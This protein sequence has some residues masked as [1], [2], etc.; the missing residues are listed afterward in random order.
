MERTLCTSP[1]EEES[2]NP[3]F[4]FHL[5]SSSVVKASLTAHPTSK[6]ILSLV[7]AEVQSL[8]PITVLLCGYLSPEENGGGRKED[9][10]GDIPVSS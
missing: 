7:H 8:K 2:C 3:N 6:S 10:E 5:K 1:W 4:K 9:L